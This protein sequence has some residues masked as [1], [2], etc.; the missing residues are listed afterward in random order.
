MKKNILISILFISVI[1]CSD[2]FFDRY[3]TDTMI[4][5]NYMKNVDELKTILNS[6]YAGMRGVFANSIVYIG[7]LPTDNAYDYKLNNSTAHISLHESN[8][9]SQNS[10][11]RDLWGACYKIINRCNIVID[12][13]EEVDSSLDVYNQLVGE[14]KFMRAYTYYVMVRIW[15]DIPL[16]LH[17]IEN[18]MDV[19]DYG[20]ISTTEIYTQIIND[21]KDAES[22]LPDFYQSDNEIGK[23]SKTAVQAIL[24]DVYLTTKDYDN[25]KIYFEKII[26]KEGDKL[27]LLDDYASI[28][29]SNNANNKEI[30]FAIQ[31]ASNQIPSMSNYLGSASLGNVQG[32]PISPKGME[33]SI[34]GVNILLMTHELESK[35]T[36]NDNRRSVIYTDLISPDYQCTIP[37]TL[38]YFDYQNLIDKKSGM[39]D[40]GCETII[41]RYSDILLKYAEC[42][43]EG[44][45]YSG[46]IN[47]IRRVRSRAGLSTSISNDYNSVFKAIEEERQ[48]ELAMEGH[49]WFDLLRTGRAIDVINSFYNRENEVVL[50]FTISVY[51][52]GDPNSPL[53]VSAYELLFPLPYDQVVLNPDKLRQNPNY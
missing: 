48:L 1:S 32:I 36:S 12:K 3:P 2:S 14:A 52:Y 38:K 29:D 24:G 20:R 37:M 42:L 26:A 39:P 50:P 21:L 30:I 40:S 46:A 45:N 5:E 19:F 33:S 28:F 35:Y 7:D 6:A 10:I 34:Y 11:I 47:Q 51:Q 4:T 53:S 25:A 43:N 8:V 22:K 9:D 17:D 27:G 13:M 15:G 18:Y 49:R 16:V 44:Q 23:I 31:Y 41:S